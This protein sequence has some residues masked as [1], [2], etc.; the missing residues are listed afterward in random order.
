[1]EIY[2]KS[3]FLNQNEIL[4]FAV[5]AIVLAIIL[6]CFIMGWMEVKKIGETENVDYRIT[7]GDD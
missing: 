3:Y 2:F 5:C 1:M 6:I 7:N 4:F